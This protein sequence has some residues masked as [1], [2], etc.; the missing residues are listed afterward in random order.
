MGGTIRTFEETHHILKKTKIICAGIEIKIQFDLVNKYPPTIN[1]K[2]NILQQM[3]LKL[4]GE[5]KLLQI[6]IPQWAAIY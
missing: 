2:K 5:D 1:S 3:L 4:V 6:L